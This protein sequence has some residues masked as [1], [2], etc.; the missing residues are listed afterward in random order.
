MF[1]D[2]VH[3]IIKEKPF[4]RDFLPGWKRLNPH[5]HGLS[6][7]TVQYNN[8]FMMFKPLVRLVITYKATDLIDGFF[9]I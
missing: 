2:D 1:Y 9:R 6:W 5:I 8:R 4:Q 3:K 7:Q